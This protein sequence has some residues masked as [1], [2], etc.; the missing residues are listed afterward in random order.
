MN[1]LTLYAIT[2]TV[3]TCVFSLASLYKLSLRL[4]T[5]LLLGLFVRIIVVLVFAHSISGDIYSFL[6]TGNV[7]LQRIPIFPSVYFPFIFYLGAISLIV[8]SYIPPLLFLKIIFL[9]V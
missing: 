7:F 1:N 2:I 8:G 9:S 3:L 5:I 6:I 4:P